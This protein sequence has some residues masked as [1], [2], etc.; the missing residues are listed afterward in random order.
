MHD[1]MGFFR[2]PENEI[3]VLRPIKLLPQSA[4]LLHQFPFYHKL[5][6][7]VVDAG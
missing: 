4:Y 1:L 6:A 5:M 7:D 2:T 3:V